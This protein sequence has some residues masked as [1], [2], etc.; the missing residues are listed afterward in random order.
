MTL[1]MSSCSFLIFIKLVKGKTGSAGLSLS[2]EHMYQLIID[3]GAESSFPTV[4]IMNVLELML[5]VTNCSAERS[6]SKMKIIKNCGLRASM[7]HQRFI[8]LA[9]LGI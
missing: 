1:A 4:E 7:T 3:K 2:Q 6:F 9:V 8:N 5:M